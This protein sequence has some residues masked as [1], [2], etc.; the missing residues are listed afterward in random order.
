MAEENLTSAQFTIWKGRKRGHGSCKQCKKQYV[1]WKKPNLC[2]CG[3]EIG[4]Q[5]IPKTK[6]ELHNNP[7]SV[8]L[9]ENTLGTLKPVKLISNDDRQFVFTNDSEKICYAKNCLDIRG[10]YKTWNLLAKFTCKSIEAEVNSCLYAVNFSNNGIVEDT[11]DETVWEKLIVLQ[12]ELLPTVVKVSSKNY[13]IIGTANSTSPMR[14]SQV[15]V[16]NSNELKFMAGK[17]MPK[18]IGKN[19]TGF[20][21]ECK[22]VSP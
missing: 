17:F 9:Y 22:T 13:A 14:Y 1:N 5:S 4:G 8:I 19:K 6:T 2:S 18:I 21:I 3:F 20:I 7:L 12:N 16:C 11:P 10:S 15:M